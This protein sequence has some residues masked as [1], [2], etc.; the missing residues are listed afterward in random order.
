MV[1]S[2]FCAVAASVG[3]LIAGRVMMGLAVGISTFTAPLYIAEIADPE[4]RGAMVSIYQLMITIG[5][6]AAF[7]VPNCAW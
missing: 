4:H 5:I 7:C 3:T 6:M 1:G 2:L